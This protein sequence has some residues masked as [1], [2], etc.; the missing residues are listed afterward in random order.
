MGRCRGAQLGLVMK[1]NIQEVK[2]S[3]FKICCPFCIR[4]I[5]RDI[6]LLQVFIDW[7]VAGGYKYEPYVPE[8]ERFG[9]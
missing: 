2:N 4:I 9:F 1:G 7:S 6:F 3:P 5:L 8:L